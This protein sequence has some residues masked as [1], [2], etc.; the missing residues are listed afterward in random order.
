MIT[1]FKIQAKEVIAACPPREVVIWVAIAKVAA[2]GSTA[3]VVARLNPSNFATARI[4]NMAI[5]E[6]ATRAR[7]ISF[8]YFLTT[9]LRL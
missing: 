8:Q 2:C 9:S 6:P 7:M 1:A 4:A 3:I 5:N